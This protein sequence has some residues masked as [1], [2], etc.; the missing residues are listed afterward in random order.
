MKYVN[1]SPHKA[2]ASSQST[3]LALQISSRNLSIFSG[4]YG[5]IDKNCNTSNGVE[6]Q[7]ESFKYQYLQKHSSSSLT[8]MLTILIEDFLV[9]KLERY[10]VRLVVN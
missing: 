4:G 3:F 1:F 5:L 8:G 9:D 6:R 10:I 7:N 2:F